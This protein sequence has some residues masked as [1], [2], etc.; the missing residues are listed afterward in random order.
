[1]TISACLIVRDAE[2][3]L[4]RCLA[5]IREQVDEIVVVD[6]G[7]RDATT[8]IARDYGAQVFDYAWRDDFGAARQCSFDL[9]RGEWVFWL[10]ADDEVAGAASLRAELA[11]APP[12]VGC[13][14][15]KYQA[16]A[17]EFGDSICELWRERCVRNKLNFRWRGRVHEVLSPLR[18]VTTRRSQSVTVLHRPRPC[19][20]TR[21]PRRNL[22]ILES[23]FAANR[24]RVAPRLLFYLGAEYADTGQYDKAAE[25]L[26]KYLTISRWD[27][28]K[29]LAL[30]RLAEV[31]RLRGKYEDATHAGEAAV[32]LLPRWPNAYF[33]LA[34][35]CYFRQDWPAV[36]RW[37]EAGSK[38]PAPDTLCVTNPLALR[39]SWIIFYTNAL[40]HL[41]RIAEAC[42]W[43]ETALRIR[44]QDP[45]HLAN[46]S[47]FST[48]EESSQ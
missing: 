14:Y 24:G 6:T 10:D 21:N 1:M 38:L 47:F 46:R 43:T 12:R 36:A 4:G 35:T 41:G 33:S 42:A 29:Y 17:D 19:R 15:W 30:M 27:E 2:A 9:A 13:F 11:S 39:Y 20:G 31:E 5:S 34:E 18:P 45:W 28:E 26:Q 44:P 25:F 40:F 8:D 7:S 3:T 37:A 22:Q 32:R 48:T 16:G 23:E